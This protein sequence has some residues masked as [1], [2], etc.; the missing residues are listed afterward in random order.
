VSHSIVTDI[1][2]SEIRAV[3]WTD[4]DTGDSPDAWPDEA[5]LRKDIR[6]FERQIARLASPNS[7]WEQGAL[8]CYQVLVE[9][10]RKALDEM[11]AGEL[12]DI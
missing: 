5:Q 1:F 2:W 10:R 8:K 7:T 9:Q 4:D 6:H 3:N 12:S 11:R